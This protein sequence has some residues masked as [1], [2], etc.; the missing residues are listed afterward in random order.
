MLLDQ[1]GKEIKQRE[2]PRDPRLKGKGGGYKLISDDGYGK[3][4]YR[5]YD[6]VTGILAEMTRN[7]DGSVTHRR[8]QNVDALGLAG[9]VSVDGYQKHHKRKMERQCIIPILEHQ[10]IMER[11]GWKPGTNI[12]DYDQKK[13]DQIINDSNGP[14]IKTRPGRISVR[15]NSWY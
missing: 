1:Y 3:R 13:F 2:I 14:V 11:C 6:P 12:A 5:D 15:Y 4:V 9:K 8:W 7:H 10:K